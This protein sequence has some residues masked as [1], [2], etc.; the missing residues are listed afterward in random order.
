MIRW[1]IRTYRS[2]RCGG[3]AI[4][5]HNR[6]ASAIGVPVLTPNL[7]AAALA[8]ITQLLRAPANGMTPTGRP[9][10]PGSACSS[11]EAKKPSKSI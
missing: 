6:R 3:R 11:Q 2:G 7:L 8:A 4:R 1:W 9:C 10:R 5:G